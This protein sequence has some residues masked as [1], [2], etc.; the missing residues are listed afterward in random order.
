MSTEKKEKA[1]LAK[2][3]PNKKKYVGIVIDNLKVE[4][5]SYKVGDVYET[6]Y[7]PLFDKLI[8]IFKI[9]KN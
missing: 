4:D 5:K 3:K 6:T 7:K 8:R 1:I 2:K 9:N